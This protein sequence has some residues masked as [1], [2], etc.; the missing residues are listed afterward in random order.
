MKVGG[1]GLINSITIAGIAAVVTAAVSKHGVEA[2]AG[3]GLGSRLEIIYT[4]CIW[5]WFGLTASVGMFVGVQQLPRGIDSMDRCIY[6]LVS[7]GY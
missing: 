6:L 2:L 1:G 7:L 4:T 5:N 3:Y